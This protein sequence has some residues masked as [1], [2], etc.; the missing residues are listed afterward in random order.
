MLEPILYLHF[1]SDSP[2]NT[3]AGMFIDDTEIIPNSKCFELGT[4][5]LQQ[6]PL[7]LNIKSNRRK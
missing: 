3:T 5:Y 4:V 7:E 6:N 1:I 2:T